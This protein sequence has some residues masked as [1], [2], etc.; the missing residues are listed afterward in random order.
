MS[1]HRSLKSNKYKSKRNVRKRWERLQK[2]ER[3]QN[4][5][6][7]NGSIYGLPAEKIN[8]V[9]IKIEKEKEEV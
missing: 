8:R 4:W 3:N 9:K 5:L 7:K 6:E 1:M 2:L